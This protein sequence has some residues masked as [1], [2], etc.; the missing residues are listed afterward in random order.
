M[1][2]Q[3]QLQKMGIKNPVMKY[4]NI[5]EREEQVRTSLD[6]LEY[7]ENYTGKLAPDMPLISLQVW[8]IPGSNFFLLEIPDDEKTD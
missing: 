7:I 4:W 1:T 3:L 2:T 8:Y 6:A 5:L